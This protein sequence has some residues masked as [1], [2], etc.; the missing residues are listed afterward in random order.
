[1]DESHINLPAPHAPSFFAMD[2]NTGQV[3]WTDNSP[4][5]NILHG[6][7]SSPSY[8]VLGGRAAGVVRRRRR[9]VVQLPGRIARPTARRSACG[10]S[11]A[12]RRRRN[13]RLGAG[14]RATTSSRTPVVYKDL[15]YVRGGRRPRAWRGGWSS[16]VH[17]SHQARRREPGAGV[18]REGPEA[19][20]PASPRAG[21]DQGARG[22]GAA[23]SELGGGMALQR[24]RCRMAT[25]RWPSKRRCTARSAAWRSRTICCIVADFSGL[26][27]CLDAKTG[28][29]HWTHDMLAA[30]WGSP[31]IVERQGVHRRRGWRYYDFQT[32][33]E[34]GDH[35]RNQHG[36][37]GLQHADRCQRGVIYF[38]QRPP[39]RDSESRIV[40][41][42]HLDRAARLVP[43]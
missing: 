32:F 33:A 9:V 42:S 6:Q 40:K 38:K 31:L 13:A 2:K 30:S 41:H 3:L 18:Q 16:L 14:P 43:R 15:V 22:G 8:A 11:T 5:G 7:W 34:A 19:P 39:V 37:R 21:G 27:H 10:S 20:D 17:R 29:P 25:A 28:K 36:K 1:M 35:Q 24:D 26:V 23:E 4:G 12:I